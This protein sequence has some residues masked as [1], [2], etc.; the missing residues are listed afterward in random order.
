MGLFLLVDTKDPS[1]NQCMPAAR[2]WHEGL[3]TIKNL[4][5]SRLIGARKVADIPS[6]QLV[7]SGNN[8]IG[9]FVGFQGEQDRGANWCPLSGPSAFSLMFYRGIPYDTPPSFFDLGIDNFEITPINLTRTS[10]YEAAAGSILLGEDGLVLMMSMPGQQQTVCVRASDGSVTHPV[11]R[12]GLVAKSWCL[13]GY[14]S[15]RLALELESGSLS[16]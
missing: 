5:L 11:G 13:C 12:Y 6:G 1:A 10:D 14:R 3:M 2:I 8:E 9:I 7:L 15:D 16:A 4:V